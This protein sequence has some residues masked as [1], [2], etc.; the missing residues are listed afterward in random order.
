[1]EIEEPRV[2][3]RGSVVRAV[4]NCLM[5]AEP[6]ITDMA[7]EEGTVSIDREWLRLWQRCQRALEADVAASEVDTM[8][9][10]EVD[11]RSY[12]FNGASSSLE[13]L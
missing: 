12:G 5:V 1:M 3:L 2:E 10:S 4:L 8:G 7:K 6:Q 11:T 9:A 13:S